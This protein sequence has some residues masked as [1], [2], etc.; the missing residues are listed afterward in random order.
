MILCKIRIGL[1]ASCLPRRIWLDSKSDFTKNGCDASWF[2]LVF[3]DLRL[4]KI[5]N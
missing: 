1:G 2:V 3:S 4:L 5:H